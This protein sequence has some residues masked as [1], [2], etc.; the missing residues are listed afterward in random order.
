MSLNIMKPISNIKNAYQMQEII[1][2][3]VNNIKDYFKQINELTNKLTDY[4]E[5]HNQEENKELIQ[6]L[7]RLITIQE[8]FIKLGEQK[9]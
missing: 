7:E 5:K 2:K 6:I 4:I 3:N 8:N 1:R 9:P